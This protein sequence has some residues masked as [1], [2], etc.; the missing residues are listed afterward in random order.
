MAMFRS[1]AAA[2]TSASR[3]EPPGWMTALAPA[4]ARASI[5][6]AKLIERIG[7]QKSL[8]TGLGIMATGALGT[9]FRASPC[10]RRFCCSPSSCP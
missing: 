9:S 1:S 2:M 7:Y 10:V 4:S 8:V 3:I 6:S 5:P